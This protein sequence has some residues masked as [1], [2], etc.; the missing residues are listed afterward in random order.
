MAAKHYEFRNRAAQT[1]ALPGQYIRRTR[2]GAS[3]KPELPFAANEDLNSVSPVRAQ[4]PITCLKAM[5][6]HMYSKAT[7]KWL[8]RK[9]VS[10]RVWSATRT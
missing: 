10:S 5:P 3:Y 9:K 6:L 8:L 7:T 2:N 1:Q 4:K